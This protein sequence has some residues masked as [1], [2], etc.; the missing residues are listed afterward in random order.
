MTSKDLRSFHSI[1]GSKYIFCSVKGL[2]TFERKWRERKNLSKRKS[3]E[4][5][6]STCKV[7]RLYC[8]VHGFERGVDAPY[9]YSLLAY[10]GPRSVFSPIYTRLLLA[11]FKN[12]HLKM[13][14]QNLPKRWYIATFLRGVII[15]NTV[16]CTIAAA[17]TLNLT[18]Q[19]WLLKFMWQTWTS[20]YFN[21]M[22][23]AM[24]YNV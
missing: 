20:S 22:I 24:V 18:K 19:I 10:F 17:K 11:Q 12:S 23:L 3:K 9:R 15:W 7:G 16:I 1:P 5:Y 14:G 6:Q 2:T 13:E 21:S 4:R 8:T